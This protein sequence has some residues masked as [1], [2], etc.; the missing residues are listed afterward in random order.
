MEATAAASQAGACAACGSSSGAPDASSAQEALA[1][2]ESQVLQRALS[3]HALAGPQG[4][5]RGSPSCA[6][7]VAAG[8]GGGASTAHVGGRAGTPA[9]Q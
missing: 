6:A 2:P 1:M 9:V 3:A 8:S 7:A 4:E 5:L